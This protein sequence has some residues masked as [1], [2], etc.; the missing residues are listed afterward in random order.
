MPSPASFIYITSR[1]PLE[2]NH[3]ELS[4]PLK[5]N[6]TMEG[7]LTP[8]PLTSLPVM[9]SPESAILDDSQ[10]LMLSTNQNHQDLQLQT[11][12]QDVMDEFYSTMPLQPHSASMS[13]MS[14]SIMSPMITPLMMQSVCDI[15]IPE[16]YA[17]LL[18]A[19]PQSPYSSYSP[20]SIL[21]SPP[22]TPLT[23][24]AMTP[25]DSFGPV[26]RQSAVRATSATDAKKVRSHHCGR[27]SSSF[28]SKYHLRRHE[29]IHSPDQHQYTCAIAGCR[30]KSYR[31]DNMKNHSE[32]HRNR[33]AR[34]RND[35]SRRMQAE[36]S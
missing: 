22:L 19:M 10:L 36:S 9:L 16:N 1:H 28:F 33:L 35:I 13:S 20:S 11:M 27:C 8:M 18:S 31:S 21:Q 25:M 30:F 7:T 14:S 15:S 12:I 23:P 3:S 4:K 32:T 24:M 2:I 6:R 26:R 29:K 34:E 5:T 17:S